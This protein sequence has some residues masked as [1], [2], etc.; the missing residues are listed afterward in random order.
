MPPEFQDTVEEEV[1]SQVVDEADASKEA[2]KSADASSSSAEDVSKPEVSDTLSVV[3]DVV[4]AKDEAEQ[5]AASSAS[6]AEGPK[7]GAD[8]TKVEQDNENYSDV[9]FNKHPRFQEVLGKLK[10]YETDA[11]RYRNVE[12]FINEQGLDGGEAADLL[13]IGGLIKTDPVRA[14]QEV[15]PTIQKLAIAAGEVLPEDL[16]S[17]VANGEMSREAAIEF[18]RQRAVLQSTEAR[19]NFDQQRSQSRELVE[20]QNAIQGTVQSWEEERHER[21]PNFAAKVPALEK[22]VAWL[23]AKEGKPNTP[24]GVRKQLQKAYDAVSASYVPPAAPVP[25]RKPAT[26]PIIGG[27]VNSNVRPEVNSTLDAVNAV[28]ARRA[29]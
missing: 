20:R 17:R 13:R 14:W 1:T 4:G 2:E 3:R 9:P 19:Q 27:Q 25:S 15:L 8:Q 6:E 11:Q 7:S 23:Q 24:E 12:T 29:G 28:L 22:E 16:K 26:R 18:S 21:D 5:S 10:T